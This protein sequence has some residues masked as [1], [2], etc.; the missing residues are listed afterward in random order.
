[1]LTKEV[2]H[3]ILVHF[4]SPTGNFVLARRVVSCDYLW[5]LVVGFMEE[6]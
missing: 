1:V 6:R 4:C 2:D 3:T 5:F